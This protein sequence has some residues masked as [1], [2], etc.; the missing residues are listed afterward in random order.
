M[1]VIGLA[2]VGLAIIAIFKQKVY[3]DEKGNPIATEIEIPLLGKVK[4]NLPAV[5]IAV[6]GVVVVGIASDLMKSRAP[7]L[8]T[9]KG[10]VRID[11]TSVAEIPD[12]IVGVT[13]GS[14]FQPATPDARE[15]KADVVIPVPNSWTSYTAYAFA[16]GG[17]KFRPRMI[18]TSLEK[19]EF[20]LELKP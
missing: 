10:E 9:F 12:V 17:G 15:L 8:V 4:T 6:L 14:W 20:K 5:A 3:L 2:I 19:P 11:R 7:K 16:L 1:L 13:S 18:G